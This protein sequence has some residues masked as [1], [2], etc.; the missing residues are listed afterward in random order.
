[1]AVPRRSEHE[2]PRR[3]RG[4]RRRGQAERGPQLPGARS[5]RWIASSRST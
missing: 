4:R 5:A 2:R 1:M 3:G